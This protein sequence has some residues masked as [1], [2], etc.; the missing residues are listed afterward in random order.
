MERTRGGLLVDR[1]HRSERL[2]PP[3]MAPRGL[4]AHRHGVGLPD[5]RR[6]VARLPA[7]TDAA[8]GATASRPRGA[9]GLG[10]SPTRDGVR[11]TGLEPRAD[12]TGPP[13]CG[14]R[15]GAPRL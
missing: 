4:A 10:A 9:G 5:L 1:G 14:R 8:P 3:R 12:A 13:A 2:R 15:V 7:A 11:G 6:E